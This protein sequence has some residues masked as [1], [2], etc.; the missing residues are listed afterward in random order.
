[1]GAKQHFSRP[2]PGRIDQD[3]LAVGKAL[4]VL[5]KQ[6]VAEAGA[7]KGIKY[8]KCNAALLDKHGFREISKSARQCAMLMVENWSAIERWLAGFEV[9]RKLNTRLSS[10]EVGSRHNDPNKLS[11]I[12]RAALGAIVGA[13]N[14]QRLPK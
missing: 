1:M 7:Y 13:L 5:R 2:S 12:A 9:D 3:W 6:A 11:G 14:L 4:L 10:G 8:S